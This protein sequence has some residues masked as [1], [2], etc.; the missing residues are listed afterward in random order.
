MY[1][2]LEEV[3]EPHFEKVVRNSWHPLFQIITKK[4]MYDH[5]DHLQ[6]LEYLNQRKEM[7][8]QTRRV[9]QHLS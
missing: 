3:N 4:M 2:A 1:K 7:S 8:Q 5:Y 9:S 6:D